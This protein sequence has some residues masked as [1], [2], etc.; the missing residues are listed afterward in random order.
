MS[1]SAQNQI[2]LSEALARC[3]LQDTD[4]DRRELVCEVEADAWDKAVAKP[5]DE[6]TFAPSTEDEDEDSPDRQTVLTIPE[7]IEASVREALSEAGF[8]PDEISSESEPS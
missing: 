3:L 6:V 1:D 7:E 8:D 2:D 5:V 4:S